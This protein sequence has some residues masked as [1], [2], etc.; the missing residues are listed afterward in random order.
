MRIIQLVPGTGGTFYCQNCVRD[1]AF[2]RALRARGHD[3]VM[4]PL[5]LPL[6]I[7]ADGLSEGVPVFFG[8][9]NV[10]LQQKSKLFRKTPRWLDR[11]FD[12]PKLLRWLARKSK[13]T[14]SRELAE[15]TMSMMRGEHG[16]QAK[17]LNRL[18]EW[19]ESQ[20]NRPD[21]ICLSNILLAGL[22]ES[23]KKRLGVV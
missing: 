3:V 18:I 17:E 6:L 2:V 19:L 11:I 13:M 10:Y 4:V 23:F 8:G 22:S 16:R 15:T 12:S 1:T 5:Y 20:D 9:I 7:D 21:I 14:S